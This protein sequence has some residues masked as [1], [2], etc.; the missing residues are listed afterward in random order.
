M[1]N[2]KPLDRVRKYLVRSH[3]TNFNTVPEILGSGETR[4]MR[5]PL[6]PYDQDPVVFTSAGENAYYEP[7]GSQGRNTIIRY[8]IPKEW[9]RRNVVEN[10]HYV[11]KH[12]EK[13]PEWS[14]GYQANE[15]ERNAFDVM[16][17][18]RTTTY[19]APIP[20]EF[21][22]EICF[23]PNGEYCYDP[24]VLRQHVIDESPSPLPNMWE[25]NYMEDF[26]PDY[27]EVFE[28]YGRKR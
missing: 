26:Y 1:P 16:N 13:N 20:N 5:H 28:K 23:G 18:G 11:G 3:A 21:I 27:P 22:D 24:V 14:L 19:R 12:V 25:W 8:H 4:P 10:P 17:G 7:R 2:L 9:H 15:L 6:D